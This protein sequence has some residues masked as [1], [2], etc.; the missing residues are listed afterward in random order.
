MVKNAV[1]AWKSQGLDVTYA[2]QNMKDF[3]NM[4]YYKSTKAGCS[5]RK[6]ETKFA[7][8]CVFDSAPELGKPLYIGSG[9]ATVNGCNDDS[10]CSSVFAGAIVEL[11]Q[12]KEN[13]GVNSLMTAWAN[14]AS[15]S[16]GQVIYTDDG[17][18]NFANN[19]NGNNHVWSIKSLD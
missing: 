5:L 12:W 10:D 11:A 8:A 15:V 2:N 14:E 17:M 3:A 18:K 1:G 19:K 4:I 9:S 6:C 7:V 13:G 16:D